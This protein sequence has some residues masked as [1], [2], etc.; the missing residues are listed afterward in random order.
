M[1]LAC[2]VGLCD[3]DGSACARL[4]SMDRFRHLLDS[5]FDQTRLYSKSDLAVSLRLLR[6]FGDVSTASR[7]P[8]FRK[9]L[10]E[11]GQRVVAGC[12]AHIGAENIQPL[13]ARL[14]AL[15]KLAVKWNAI[16]C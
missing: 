7:D 6:A 2:F 10:F 11:R 3:L 16:P 1:T 8:A 14:N 4:H 9:M 15:E 13:L 5:A 12:S